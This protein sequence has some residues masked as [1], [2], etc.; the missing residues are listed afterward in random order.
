MPQLTKPEL[1][2]HYKQIRMART[3]DD[4]A[5][6]DSRI[7][8]SFVESSAYLGGRD[9]LI[10]VSGEIEIGTK[11]IMRYVFDD[12]AKGKDKRLLC[13]RCESGTNIMHFYRVDS[14]D[15]LEEGHFGIYEPKAE[16]WRVDDFKDAVCVVP[17]LSFDMKGHRLGFGKGFYDRFLAD[18]EGVKIGLCCESCMS[19]TVLPHEEHDVCVDHVITEKGMINI[20]HTED[21]RKG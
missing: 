10:Y 19:N 21:K 18:L 8:R 3:A 13:P 6:T 2:K 20:P 14:F 4:I 15:D 17:A 7:C 16:C 1:R 5:E 12:I 11:E 9:I